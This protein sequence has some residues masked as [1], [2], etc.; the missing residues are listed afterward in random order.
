MFDRVLWLLL[1]AVHALPALAFVRPAMITRLYGVAA[2]DD[3]FLM[4]RHR[5]ALFLAIV[6]IAIW[7]AVDPATR[8]MAGVAIAI[9]M[10]SFL[11]LYWQAGAPPGLRLIARVDLV[12]LPVLILAM[13]RAL[14]Q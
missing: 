7:A 4:I 5:A 10:L 12:A 13:W 9:S 8:R 2:T 11:W 3:L 6:V 14:A 1:A